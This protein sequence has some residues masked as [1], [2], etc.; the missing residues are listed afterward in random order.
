MT[1]D[2]SGRYKG[3]NY[4][5]NYRRPGS[6][7]Q[8]RSQ[9]GQG[10]GNGHGYS[11]ATGGSTYA[12]DRG[13]NHGYGYSSQNQASPYA[14]DNGYGRQSCSSDASAHPPGRNTS[15]PTGP[16]SSYTAPLPA[17]P[18]T[19]YESKPPPLPRHPPAEA[20][21][22]P[23]KDQEPVNPPRKTTYASMPD[24]GRED[25][26]ISSSGGPSSPSSARIHPSRFAQMPDSSL[27]SSQGNGNDPM[28]SL[29]NGQSPARAQT[30]V[31]VDPRQSASNQRNSKP[32]PLSFTTINAPPGVTT[33]TSSRQLQPNGSSSPAGKS[34]LDSLEKLRQ[35]KEQ[36]AA[37]R[38]SVSNMSG[39]EMSKLAQVAETFLKSQ[40]PEASAD[41]LQ[42]LKQMA[43]TAEETPSA[44]ATD[45]RQLS[46]GPSGPSG[47]PERPT[48]RQAELKERLLALKSGRD[49]TSQN[50]HEVSTAAS[51]GQSEVSRPARPAL[52]NG[53]GPGQKRDRDPDDLD[54]LDDDQ[55][56]FRAEA[57]QKAKDRERE[58][59]DAIDTFRESTQR[60]G[61]A[62]PQL[63]KPRPSGPSVPSPSHGEGHSPARP[64]RENGDDRRTF[65]TERIDTRAQHQQPV[66]R[67]PPGRHD[68]H[69]GPR[70]G[71]PG[72]AQYDYRTGRDEPA[73]G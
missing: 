5:P 66:G 17:R 45:A 30:P 59:Q 28:S 38:K 68:A 23:A 14:R 48:S 47:E 39:P 13:Q 57:W 2:P 53:H 3:N 6:A 12:Q 35:F 40:N 41:A 26:E 71:S 61:H 52:V 19:P 70:D 36:V 69:S 21:R 15:I 62:A 37:S 24:W 16:A 20:P 72:K 32:A 60:Q 18:V 58:V 11:S 7:S 43:S 49:G 42:Q 34:P 22:G 31:S 67:S 27:S 73:Q 64:I 8:S 65:L 54:R 1:T 46:S 4:D 44:P 63:P 10:S 33:P 55:K 56:R 9:Y 50:P 29:H 25:G 51:S